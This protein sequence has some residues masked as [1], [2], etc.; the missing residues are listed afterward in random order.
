MSRLS[1]RAL[2]AVGAGAFAVSLSVGGAG[3]AVAHPRGP[4]E[5][6]SDM[7]G[8]WLTPLT[9]FR[10]GDPINWMH[11]MT[12]R[13][14]LGSAAVAWE[15]W[16]D[17]TLQAA[18]CTAAKKGKQTGVN[19]SKSSRVLMVMGPNGVVH[20]VGTYGTFML[21]PDGEGMTAVMLSHGQKDDWTATPDPTTSGQSP[22]AFRQTST[23]GIMYT[24]K[25][26][27]A[28]GGTTSA[29]PY[30]SERISSRP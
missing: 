25:G 2:A 29:Y 24:W 1:S 15:E 28:V 9:G 22:I 30:T 23:A 26:F 7:K 12:V 14:V 6:M 19:W 20:G 16:L 17:C 18:D 3:S 13:K 10:E 8:V 5:S 4:I 11:R 27:F 21:T